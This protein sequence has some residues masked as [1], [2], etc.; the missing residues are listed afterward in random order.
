MSYSTYTN[1]YGNTIIMKINDDES[2]TMFS[3]DPA[4]CDYQAYL[5]WLAE[6]AVTEEPLPPLEPNN[7]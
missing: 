1:S 4:N 2:V 6:T 5:A 3:E 7:G